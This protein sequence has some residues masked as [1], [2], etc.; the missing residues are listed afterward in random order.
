MLH[1]TPSETKGLFC[2]YF[3]SFVFIKEEPDMDSTAVVVC[4]VVVAS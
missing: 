1:V 4:Q 3:I 2:D